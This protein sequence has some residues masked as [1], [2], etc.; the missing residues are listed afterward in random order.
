M[1]IDQTAIE[2][3]KRYLT[4]QHSKIRLVCADVTELER[5]F[6]GRVYD[7]ILCAGVLL[8]LREDTA[9]LAVETMIRHASRLVAIL[10]RAHP[11]IDNA[12]LTRS[13]QHEWDSEQMHNI[14]SMVVRAGGEVVFRHWIGNQGSDGIHFVFSS[15]RAHGTAVSHG[16]SKFQ[17]GNSA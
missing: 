1:D 6:A 9:A 14:D 3:G 10:D 15:G 16:H 8:Y 4:E 2:L 12:E 5:V 17:S 7:V 11:L 13:E